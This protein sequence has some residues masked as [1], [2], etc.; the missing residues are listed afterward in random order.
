[1]TRWV[2]LGALLAGCALF[3]MRVSAEEGQA[4]ASPADL[5]TLQKRLDDLEKQVASGPQCG[6]ACCDSM[7]C[8]PCHCPGVVFGTEMSML[9]FH[10]NIGLADR[11]NDLEAAP[12][13]WAGWTTAGGLGARIRWFDYQDTSSA[14]DIERVRL[15]TVD[16]EITDSFQ[17]GSKWSG[18]LS[19]G[20]RYAEENDLVHFAIDE[21]L[22]RNVNSGTG[23]LLG[24]ELYR[25]VTD[26]FSLFVLGRESLL[27]GNTS[28]SE[29]PAAERVQNT[30][31]AISEIQ[32][33]GEWRKALNGTA[34]LF[35]RTAVE[36]Q[37]WGGPAILVEFG[38]RDIG[39][40]GGTMAV[41][42][43]R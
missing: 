15:Y 43:C 19:G 38:S 26:R 31:F 16:M 20:V 41:G 11:Y 22:L 24:V 1:M 3:A 25:Q 9:R 36:A 34:Y 2:G 35:A 8:D 5:A 14:S 18:L 42:I 29:G 28:I 6:Q 40:V 23:P 4:T 32:L 39:L 27:F 17:L 37:W 33:G 13:I 7:C 21:P 30:L 10:D 12:R